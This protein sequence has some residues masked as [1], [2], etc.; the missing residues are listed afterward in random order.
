MPLHRIKYVVIDTC[1]A[2][3][4]NIDNHPA[5]DTMYIVH[6]SCNGHPMDHPWRISNLRSVVSS[7][8]AIVKIDN[9][10]P[11]ICISMTMTFGMFG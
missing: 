4:I 5:N 2:S 3:Y 6:C 1:M 8:F 9:M 11:Y 7:L 10:R